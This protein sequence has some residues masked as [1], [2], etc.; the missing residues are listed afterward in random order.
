MTKIIV[1]S[2]SGYYKKTFIGNRANVFNAIYWFALEIG[3]S[4][5]VY[6]IS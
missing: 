6:V 3:E 5:Y 4:L 2:E 1:I